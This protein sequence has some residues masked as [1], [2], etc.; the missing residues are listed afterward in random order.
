MGYTLQARGNWKGNGDR[1]LSSLVSSPPRACERGRGG[2]EAGLLWD[3]QRSPLTPWGEQTESGGQQTVEANA[4]G[5]QRSDISVMGQ[6]LSFLLG[7][8]LL[9]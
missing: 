4:R 6:E 2:G 1:C 5:Y 7:V 8:V 9:S 3:P